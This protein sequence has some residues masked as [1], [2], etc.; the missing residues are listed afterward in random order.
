MILKVLTQQTHCVQVIYS[1][2]STPVSKKNGII[3]TVR[4]NVSVLEG[5]QDPEIANLII[6]DILF[7]PLFV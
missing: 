5:I 4:N 6:G 7:R 2:I 3:N 1:V